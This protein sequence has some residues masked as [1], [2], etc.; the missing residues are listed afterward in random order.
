MASLARPQTPK[1]F[2]Q[3]RPGTWPQAFGL[4]A[5]PPFASMAPSCEGV[6]ACRLPALK[7]LKCSAA[8]TL[9]TG[10]WS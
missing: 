3:L 2:R 8:G 6:Q 1:M 10:I 9:A 7:P 5:L 4:R